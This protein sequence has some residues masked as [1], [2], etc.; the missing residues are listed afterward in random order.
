MK[1]HISQQ[2]AK[3]QLQML[4][5]RSTAV[6][7]TPVSNINQEPGRALLDHL[8]HYL[9]RKGT[10]RMLLAIQ[11]TDGSVDLGQRTAGG[12]NLKKCTNIQNCLNTISNKQ[13]NT[14]VI[15]LHFYLL[16]LII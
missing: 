11:Q 14:F 1:D 10:S 13:I 8:C 2:S 4:D 6:H 16:L 7:P 3:F 9:L 15:S 12:V 5:L